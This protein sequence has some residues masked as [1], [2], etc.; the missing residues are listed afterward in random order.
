[1]KVS[2]AI[3]TRLLTMAS[4]HFLPNQRIEC[5]GHRFQID[6]DTNVFTCSVCDGEHVC[7]EGKCDY[8]IYNREQTSVCTLTG[9]CHG[10]RLCEKYAGSGG[11]GM[12]SVSDPFYVP[13]GKRCQQINNRILKRES[14]WNLVNSKDIILEP[15]LSDA[16]KQ[17][18]LWQI[19][20]LWFLLVSR[21]KKTNG[22]LH[23]KDRRTFVVSILFSLRDG[24]CCTESTQF[25]VK[26]HP[27]VRLNVLNKKRK[28]KHFGVSDIRCGQ[29]LIRRVFMGQTSIGTMIDINDV[30]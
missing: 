6:S 3:L 29:N 16:V 30:I 25:L 10:P 21:V 11:V 22:S 28:Y 8:V 1:M 17:K 20:E 24:M 23:R 15:D 19:S 5:P 4:R 13:R 12:I 26:P 2:Q 27:A 14:I 7:V 9:L 18:L